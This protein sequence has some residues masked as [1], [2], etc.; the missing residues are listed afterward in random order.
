MLHVKSSP[1]SLWRGMK[2]C[3]SGVP[4]SWVSDLLPPP[5]CKALEVAMSTHHSQTVSH[6]HRHPT[7]SCHRSPAD[8][9][10]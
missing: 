1:V 4:I 10:R 8:R 2:G 5:V 3:A 9:K 6:H 7:C